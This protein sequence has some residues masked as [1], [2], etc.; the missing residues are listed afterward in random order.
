MGFA[1]FEVVLHEGEEYKITE[2][3]IIKLLR[4]RGNSCDLGIQADPQIRI[5]R[6]DNNQSE[7]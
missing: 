2:D 5:V 6:V 4:I 7:K 1:E 3:I